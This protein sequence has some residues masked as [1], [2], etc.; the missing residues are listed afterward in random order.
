[1]ELEEHY[2]KAM[3]EVICSMMGLGN[4]MGGYSCNRVQVFAYPVMVKMPT[5]LSEEWAHP[6]HLEHEP[7]DGLGFEGGVGREELSAALFCQV[8]EDGT[9]LEHVERLPSC[10]K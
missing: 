2:A 4:M 1:M 5:H 7:L 6:S 8:E 9:A 10:A 3:A